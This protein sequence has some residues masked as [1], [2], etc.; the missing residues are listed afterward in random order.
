MNLLPIPALDGGRLVFI[1]LEMI[2]RKKIS[3]EKEGLVHF[4]GLVV[5][6]AFMIFIMANDIRNIFFI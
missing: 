2:R 3:P 1:L 5:L 4:A 6:L